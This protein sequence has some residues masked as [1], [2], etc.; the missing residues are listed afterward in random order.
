MAEQTM[1]VEVDVDS[2]ALLKGLAQENHVSMAQ[3]FRV[4]VREAWEMRP[5]SR[6]TGGK[7]HEHSR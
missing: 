5:E 4:I 7:T 2:R 3:M 6:R 1:S